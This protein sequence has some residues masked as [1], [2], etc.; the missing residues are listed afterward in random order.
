LIPNRNTDHQSLTSKDKPMKN[1]VG[2]AQNIV[3]FGGTSE[4]GQAI[5]QRVVQ[6]GVSRLVLV[7]R[8]IELASSSISSL[9]ERHPD[10]DVHHVRFD[11]T[12]A[13]AMTHVVAEVADVIGDIDIAVIAQGVLNE[14]VDY[15]A[16]PSLLSAVVD[17]NFTATMT[18]MYSLA[19]RMRAQGYG[20]I[21]LL[22]SVAG[23]R[24]RRGNPVYGATKAGI[25][26]FALALDHELS[27]SGA[28][29]LVVR[30]GFVTT[31]MTTGMKK[32]PF[33]TDAESV[34]KSVE[35][36]L[37]SNKSVIWA[38]SVLQWLFLVLKN[39]PLVV[40]RKLPL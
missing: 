37:K 27:G 11:A 26:G 19:G 15:F 24:V 6:P 3:L 14:G 29:V 17:V 23:E 38:P 36:G 18:L 31:K 22:S 2:V 16:D 12:D 40:W 35:R 9:V 33:S 25:D 7:S 39:L 21:V 13:S 5:L 28:S 1:G 10:L 34:A 20:K 30:P 4:I 32:A 8:D